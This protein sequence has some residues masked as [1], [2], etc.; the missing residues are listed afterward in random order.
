V[1]LLPMPLPAVL[2]ALAF[3]VWSLALPAAALVRRSTPAQALAYFN[4]GSLYP[5]LVL[6]AALL[7]LA[8]VRT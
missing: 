3:G 8:V 2:L 6:I 5:D 1:T 4:R 7:G